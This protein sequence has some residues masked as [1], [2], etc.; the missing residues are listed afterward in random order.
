MLFSID[1]QAIT[2]DVCAFRWV[3]MLIVSLDY[4]KIYVYS[5]N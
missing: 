5:N 3:K 1:L 2:W 4:V